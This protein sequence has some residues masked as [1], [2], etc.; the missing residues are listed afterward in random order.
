MVK[1]SPARKARV[2]KS[3]ESAPKTKK[4][5]SIRNSNAGKLSQDKSK[6][7]AKSPSRGRLSKPESSQSA[8]TPK[9]KLSFSATRSK[10]RERQ[11]RP[12]ETK[13]NQLRSASVRHYDV[14]VKLL[15][16][17]EYEKAKLAFK[18]IVNDFVDDKEVLERARLHLKL[19]EQ[20]ITRTPAPPKTVDDQYNLAV[21]LM[22][23]GR[24]DEALEL[25]QK[26]LKSNPHCD[27][28]LYAVAAN[29]C[30][31]GEIEAALANLQTAISLKPENRFLAQRDTDFD[32]LK[33][34]SR[35]VSLVFPERMS[36]SVN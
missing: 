3:K 20:K 27:Y 11:P 25:L 10:P 17:H 30:R 16:S 14:A 15:Y 1:V 21:A 29:R 23:E 4:N 26:A 33:E 5:R 13:A 32:V 34:D 7:K 22:N 2:H 24:D 9:K 28:V 6:L 18:K 8:R 35:F 12:A 31:K 19:C 36:S